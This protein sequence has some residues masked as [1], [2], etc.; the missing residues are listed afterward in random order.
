KNQAKPVK[1]KTNPSVKKLFVLD[2]NVLLHDAN[3]LFKFEEHDVFIPMIVLEELDHQ[4]KGLS[5]V[6][7]NARQVSRHL[8]ALVDEQDIH[9]GIA[10]NHLGH[11]EA[12]G[13]LF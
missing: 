2:T 11:I 3:C 4:K 10:L 6:A 13:Q 9:Q 1:E 8:E 7:R 5:E 12:R